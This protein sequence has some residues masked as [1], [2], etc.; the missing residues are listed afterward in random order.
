MR[1]HQVWIRDEEGWFKVGQ[2][3]T[4]RTAVRA[5]S[6]LRDEGERAKALPEGVVPGED[7]P[8]LR[9]DCQNVTG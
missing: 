6:A 4:E 2:P 1:R 3:T 8:R 5:A 9:T 7:L